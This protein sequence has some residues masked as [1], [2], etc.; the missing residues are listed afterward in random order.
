MLIVVRMAGCCRSTPSR[1]W[2]R[3]QAERERCGK[4]SSG[5]GVGTGRMRMALIVHLVCIRCILHMRSRGLA[6][7]VVVA[8]KADDSERE[9]IEYGTLDLCDAGYHRR[10]SLA[11]DDCICRTGG[12]GSI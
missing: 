6:V 11:A 4:E 7:V 8:A 5:V 12:R 2:T 9:G 3:I 10:S 1:R